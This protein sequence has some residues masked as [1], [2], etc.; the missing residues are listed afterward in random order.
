MRFAA[1][2]AAF[3]LLIGVWFACDR[4]TPVAPASSTLTI[5]GNP[6]RIAIDGEATIT[7]LARKADGTAVNP[8]TQ[9]NFST[10][11]G[12]IDQLV[13]TDDSGIAEAV[14]R[15]DN[16]IGVAT[17]TAE[18][19]AAGTATLDIQIGALAASIS[20]TARPSTISKDLPPG[21]ETIKLTATVI[22]DLSNAVVGV[23]VTFESD[24]GV[25]E[26]E[27]PV[28]T[29]KNGVAKDTLTISQI[30]NLTDGFFTITVSTASDGGTTVSDSVDIDV[31]GFPLTISLSAQPSSIPATGG[32]IRLS[33]LV[34]DDGADPAE[35]EGV[36]FL[37]EVGRLSSGGG[38]I[39]TD[40]NGQAFDTLFVSEAELGSLTG[41][42]LPNLTVTAEVAGADG[43]LISDTVEIEVEAQ[44][45]IAGFEF[46]ATDL[47]VLFTNTTTGDAPLFLWDFGDG[48]SSNLAS[49]SHLY[50]A[51]GTYFVTLTATNEAGSDTITKPV[52]VE[53]T[54]D[55]DPKL[56]VVVEFDSF[57]D[58]DL[59]S[60]RSTG[61]D[62]IFSIVATNT[63]DVDLAGVT[64]VS[65]LTAPL[66]CVPTPPA[67]L[68]PTETIT[69]TQTYTVTATDAAAGQVAN[70]V[71]AD[72][73]TATAVADTEVVTIP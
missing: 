33:A 1:R 60:D 21:G 54:P 38:L 37:T 30:G 11:L 7:V 47:N 6:T 3:L 12:V 28:N 10:T 27:G 5:A 61:D 71:T 34:R 31:T 4:P 36:N 67:T 13:A 22:D 32:T 48:F 53:A 65:T 64:V 55:P 43:G 62:L 26:S 49:P 46:S 69:C 29:N 59:S 70:T 23:P 35:G 44:P 16:R 19:G 24:E 41:T 42:A 72:N 40:A 66:V 57:V 17:V 9:I 14:L 63:G 8:G 18:S 20:L 50:A 58:N 15:G 2:T 39:Q 73:A 56:A 52:T 25:L 51:D 45:P 68:Q